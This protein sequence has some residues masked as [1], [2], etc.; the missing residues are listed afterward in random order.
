MN[1]YLNRYK[2]SDYHWKKIFRHVNE[3]QMQALERCNADEDIIS[4]Y[5][6]FYINRDRLFKNIFKPN[7]VSL[8]N[9]ESNNKQ[10]IDEFFYNEFGFTTIEEC[11]EYP[12]SDLN[13][14][15][16]FKV[17]YD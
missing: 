12:S 8:I 6:T 17:I 4:A 7:E 9:A 10:Q 5:N 14:L 16:V 15:E 13:C 11:K 1:F 3:N 2:F